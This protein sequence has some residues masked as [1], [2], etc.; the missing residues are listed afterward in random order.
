MP[1]NFGSGGPVGTDPE[2]VQLMRLYSRE[3]QRLTME[4]NTRYHEPE[5]LFARSI[6]KPVGEG[7]SLFSPFPQTLERASPSARACSST[8]TANSGTRGGIFI[9]DGAPIGHGVVL[10]TL[11]HD[12]DPA[13]RQQLYPALIRIGKNAWTGAH[14][15]ILQGVTVAAGAVVNRD[16]P[17]NTVAG[18]VPAKIIQRIETE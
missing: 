14:A 5:E 1:E 7:F 8:R 3:A 11:N 17:A 2:Y 13:R 12:L 10:A 6:G 16:V 15:T 4:L 18:G 9:G